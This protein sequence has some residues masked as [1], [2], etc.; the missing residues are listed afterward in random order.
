MV[1]IFIQKILIEYL[2]YI[3]WNEE[4]GGDTKVRNKQP[5]HRKCVH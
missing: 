3:S 1:N 2:Q 5:S 4:A